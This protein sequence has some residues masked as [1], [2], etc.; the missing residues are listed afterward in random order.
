VAILMKCQTTEVTILIHNSNNF[1]KFTGKNISTPK[2]KS[3]FDSWIAF[4]LEW[5][6]ANTKNNDFSIFNSLDEIASGTSEAPASYNKIVTFGFEDSY[7]NSGS[8]DT[9]EFDSQKSFLMAIKEKLLGYQ[10]CFAWGSKAVTRKEKGTGKIEGINGDLVVLDS[11]FKANEISSIVRYDGFS[12]IP[13]IKKDYQNY[14]MVFIADIDLL[15][16]FAKPLV[17][18]VFKNKYKGFRLDTVGKALL[19][20]GKLDNKTGAKLDKMSIDE[21]KSYCLYDAHIVA[22]LARINNSQILKIMNIIASHTELKFEEVCHKGMSAIW[23]KILNDAISKKVSLIGFDGLPKTLRKLYSNKTSFVEFDDDGYDYEHDEFEDDDEL[24]EYKENSYDQ[25]VEL[26]EQRFK[27]RTSFDSNNNN[28]YLYHKEKQKVVRKYKGATVL[29]P[30]RGLHYDVYVFDVTSLYPTMIINYN[31]S[32]ETINCH[33]CKN[34]IKARAMFY[35][36]HIKDCQFIPPKDNGYWICQR[37]KGLFS[38]ILQELTEQRIKYKKEEKEIES[39]AVKAIINSGYGVFGHPHFKYY[40]P[41]VAEII[42]TLGRRTLAEMQNIANSL[43]L[44]IL[45]GDTD[46]LF[47]NNLSSKEDAAEF[48][49]ECKTKLGIDVSHEKTY[50]KLILVSKKHYVGILSDPN[51]APIIKGMEGIKSDRPAFI[52]TVFR[53]MIN[54]IKND[55]D[56][57]L[58]LRLALNELDSRQVPVEKLS[59]SLTLS[60][61]PQEYANDCLQKRLGTKNNLKKGDTVVYY[62][63][64]KQEI[65]KDHQGNHQI[66]RVSESDDPADISYSKY[67][68]MFINCV[69]DVIEILG[70]EIEQ[71]LMPKKRLAD[72]Y[73]SISNN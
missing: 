41:K 36:E 44:T 3:N 62:K 67:K 30:Q 60:K 38:K 27:E 50:R 35:Q 49:D 9:T 46:S 55:T 19:G 4:D 31:I 5:K 63:G 59:I 65:V 22:Q 56:P 11:N 13:Y 21:R 43:N 73:L 20:Y 10:Y 47:V 66:K 24:S 53:E 52:Q 28:L 32:P 34:N 8:Y 14:K 69:K 23:R 1:T 64:D 72:H 58:K 71:D 51:Q 17:R 7:G 6:D 25:Y 70:Y 39:L 18:L 15:K 2:F 37:K 45:Y 29:S 68:E 54:D 48:I 42:T 61:N 57:I 12:S 40:D 26:M 16:V 33:C